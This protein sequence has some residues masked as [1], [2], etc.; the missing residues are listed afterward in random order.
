MSFDTLQTQIVTKNE[1]KTSNNRERRRGKQ[2]SCCSYL[3]APVSVQVRPKQKQIYLTFRHRVAQILGQNNRLQGRRRRVKGLNATKRVSHLVNLIKELFIE[4][5]QNY[6]T[7][8]GGVA[9]GRVEW[10]HMLFLHKKFQ[11]I[12]LLDLHYPHDIAHPDHILPHQG[13]SFYGPLTPH[14]HPY[15]PQPFLLVSKNTPTI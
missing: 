15:L 11:G 13:G 12:N 5:L 6:W 7:I 2:Y 9:E 1:S 14:G 4:D 3:L 8:T 10:T